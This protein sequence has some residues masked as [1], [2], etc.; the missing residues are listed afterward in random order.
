MKI[1][2]AKRKHYLAPVDPT[3]QTKVPGTD[4]WLW[5]AAGIKESAPENDEETDD[6]GYF[7]GDGTPDEIVTSK[8]LGRSFEGHRHYGDAAQDYVAS[9]EYEIGDDLLVWYKEISANGKVQ[10]L[11]LARLSEIEI[12]DGEATELETIAFKIVWISKP[13]VSEVI[14]DGA[15]SV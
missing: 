11:G 9:K 15:T 5:I 4:A 1:K 14:A 10:K 3:D 8:K 6:S 12:G 2:N 7:D 13:V